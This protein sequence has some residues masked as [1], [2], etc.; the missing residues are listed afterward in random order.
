MH[1]IECGGGSC[2][3]L[4]RGTLHAS[5]SAPV[6]PCQSLYL[7]KEVVTCCTVRVSFAFANTTECLNC[8]GARFRVEI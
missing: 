5:L 4:I 8:N 1:V 2:Q 6:I 7:L 3:V